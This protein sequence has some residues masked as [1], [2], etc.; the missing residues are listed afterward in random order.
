MTPKI[1]FFD[2]E[3]APP[4]AWFWE[5]NKEQYIGH[6]Q[7]LQY[8]FF[9]SI[10]WQ[11]EW[12]NDP[13]AYSLAD[14]P[15]AFKND[16]SSDKRVVQ[17]AADLIDDCDI[18]V[19]HN[20]KRFDWRHFKARMIFHKIKPVKKPYIVDTLAEAKTAAFPSNSLKG[21]AKHLNII[22]K[23]YN[24]TDM[25]DLISGPIAKRLDAIRMQTAYGLKDIPPLKELYYRLR[26]Y[27][28]KHPNIGAFT[29]LPCCPK[30]GSDHI[31]NR[32]TS[33]IQGG[34]ALRQQY[35]CKNPLCG[36]RFKGKIVTKAKFSL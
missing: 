1:L 7:I 30:C 20:G 22:E 33:V 2:T 10:Q 31:V 6:N 28:E 17:K 14:N 23:G 13:S 16:P 24:E 19:A 15:S 5:S 9:T 34:N 35:A 11:W 3:R 4:I 21:L 36:C 29:G 12:E 32:G 26:P 27:S 18:L 8:G 25:A